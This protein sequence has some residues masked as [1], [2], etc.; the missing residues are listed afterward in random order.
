MGPMPS[1]S[2]LPERLLALDTRRVRQIGWPVLGI[3]LYLVIANSLR[4]RWPSAGI[5]L[6]IAALT[7]L[8][9]WFNA[10]GRA[11]QAVRLMVA[12][13]ALGLS[14]LMVAG[15]GLYDTAVMAF[16][17]LIV[18]AAMLGARRLTQALVWFLLAALGAVF[19]LNH[20]GVL[21]V[22]IGNLIAVGE[23][24]VTLVIRLIELGLILLMTWLLVYM[25]AGDLRTTIV[26]LDGEKQALLKSQEEIERLVQRD[27]LTGLPNRLLARDRLEQMLVQSETSG[28]VVAVLF[29]DLDNF[30]TINDSLG[31]DA[32]DALLK[33]V[34]GKLR[35]ALRDNDTVARMSGDE[36]LILLSNLKSESTIATVIGK[37]NRVFR[38]PFR[39]ND[40]DALVTA[41][42][43]IAVAPRDGEDV[44]QLLRNADLAMYKAKD[45]GRNTF[46]FFDASMNESVAE[47]LRIGAG[48]RTAL[49]NGELR[50]HYQPQYDLVSGRILGAEALLRWQHPE[51]GAI[52]PVR[53]IPVAE[54]SGLIHEI[55]GWVLHQACRDAQ[56]WCEEGLGE[57]T[58]AVNVSPLQLRRDDLDAVVAS[59]LAAS[60]LAGPRLELEL[61]ESVLVTD[62]SDP[63]EVLRRVSSRG[64]K[65]AIDDFG[66][67]YSNLSY[68]RRFAVHRL[69]IDRSFVDRICSDA[70]DEALVKAIVE[71]AHCLSLSVV[72]EGI[73]DE[74]A[75]QKLRGLGCESGQGF[76]WSPAVPFAEFTALVRA[77]E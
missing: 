53:F 32:G 11:P 13:L 71:M 55:G 58:V 59:A 4:T 51:L 15:E 62:S 31:H 3:F 72:A 77:Q 73:E 49:A 34:A 25:L 28:R 10:H 30:K 44:D 26:Q 76:L 21:P 12:S 57:L 54:R 22:S 17:T 60:G 50:L 43:G 63:A 38:E 48:L 61:T 27:A 46:C 16:P 36:F 68:L 24:D 20:F 56:R 23:D 67:G 70:N 29:L 75:L 37:I 6:A 40:V 52:P 66:T 1:R 7:G 69:K 19:A 65:V 2:N 5:D 8:A 35:A 9:L 64:V 45:A 47:Q 14:V 41:S 18:F 39:V 42:L 74:E 33:Q